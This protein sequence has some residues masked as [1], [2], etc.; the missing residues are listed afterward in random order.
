MW[1]EVP[2]PLELEHKDGC[3]GNN[4]R[5]NLEMLCPNCHALTSTWRGRNKQ[6]RR[7]RVPDEVLIEALVKANWNVRQALLQVYLA[8]KGGNYQRCYK[9]K[10]ELGLD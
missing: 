1:Q 5:S 8:P 2:I 6:I 4:Q 3:R 7:K 10:K 9:L